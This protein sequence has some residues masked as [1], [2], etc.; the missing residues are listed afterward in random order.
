MAGRIGERF[1][2]LG[3]SYTIGEGV[4]PSERW[5][6]LV[7]VSLRDAGVSIQ[8]PVYVAKTG[9]TTEELLAALKSR[10]ESGVFSLVSVQA[11]V[12]DQ[13]RGY[14]GERFLEGFL[15]LLDRAEALAGGSPSRVVAVSIPD[16]SVTPFAAGR[17]RENI[18]AG[19]D[20]FNSLAA[21]SCAGRGITW[22]DVTG[23]SR[24]HGAEEGMLAADG[25]H[26]SGAMYALWAAALSDIFLSMLGAG[27]R[28]PRSGH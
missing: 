23:I 26:P 2:A 9:W 18:A 10:P 6:A 24:E 22:A 7:A 12:N 8:E 14:S 27:G 25:L 5:P 4:D 20:L 11:G 21:S 1:L 28:G 16:W 19:I 13:Y 3:D 15:A 17:D